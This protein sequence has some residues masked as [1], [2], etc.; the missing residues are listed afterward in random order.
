MG[1][2][3]EFMMLQISGT[4]RLPSHPR[5]YLRFLAVTRMGGRNVGL[6]AGSRAGGSAAVSRFHCLAQGIDQGLNAGVLH[7]H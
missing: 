2:C 5:G 6:Y 4:T 1:E 3:W 7:F